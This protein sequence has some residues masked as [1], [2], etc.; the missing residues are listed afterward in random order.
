MLQPQDIIL[1]FYKDRII[2]AIAAIESNALL[3]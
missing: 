3:T 2:L 1:L